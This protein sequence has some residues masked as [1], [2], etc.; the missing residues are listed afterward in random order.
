MWA[1]SVAGQIAARLSH[2]AAAIAKTLLLFSLLYVC[3]CAFLH[4]HTCAERLVS[5]TFRSPVIHLFSSALVRFLRF[6][7]GLGVTLGTFR[8]LFLSRS[9]PSLCC[10]MFCGCGCSEL[11]N[12]SSEITSNRS[13]LLCS[14]SADCFVHP[15]FLQVCMKEKFN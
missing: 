8:L 15:G 10:E 1:A 12:V 6:L 13:P 14:S 11:R 3:F 4:Q 7:R 9:S 5:E 2:R